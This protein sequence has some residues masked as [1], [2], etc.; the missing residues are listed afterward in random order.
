MRV[1]M[2]LKSPEISSKISSTQGG[3]SFPDGLPRP[4]GGREKWNGGGLL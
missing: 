3:P 4:R 2:T 1:L